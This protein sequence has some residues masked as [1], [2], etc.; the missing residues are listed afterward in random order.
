MAE[1]KLVDLPMSWTSKYL[2]IRL[3]PIKLFR[4]FT[5]GTKGQAVNCVA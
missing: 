4:K 2:Q 1:L 3:F 5:Q